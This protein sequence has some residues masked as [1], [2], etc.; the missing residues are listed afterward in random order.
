MTPV[1]TRPRLALA[2]RSL[3]GSALATLAAGPAGA[4]TNWVDRLSSLTAQANQGTVGIMAG[5]VDGTY[6]RIA[7]DLMNVLDEGD[8]MRVV[9]MLGRGSVQNLRDI[10]LLRGIDIGIVQSDVL[11]FAKREGLLP[12]IDRLVQY[13]TK[14]YDEEIHLL[15]RQDVAS[16]QDLAGKTVN[17]DVRGSGTAMTASLVLEALGVPVQIANDPQDLALTA[18]EVQCAAEGADH[19]RFAVRPAEGGAR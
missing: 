10:V 13:I 16:V 19:C 6:I 4:Q 2:R 17:V 1:P 14:L 5:G 18:E 3:L 11:A 12:G 9:A 8:R 7:A 15:A